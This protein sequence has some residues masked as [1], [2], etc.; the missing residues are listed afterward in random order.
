V[1]DESVKRLDAELVFRKLRE[2]MEKKEEKS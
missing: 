1:A 2:E